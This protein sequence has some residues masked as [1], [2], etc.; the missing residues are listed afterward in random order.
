MA[1]MPANGGLLRFSE[2]SPDTEFGHFWS[3]ISESLRRTFEKLPFLGDCGRRPGSICTASPAWQSRV[4]IFA[5]KNS[6]VSDTAGW[7]AHAMEI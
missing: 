7:I 3:E 4:T 1:E 5:A 6:L 2:R